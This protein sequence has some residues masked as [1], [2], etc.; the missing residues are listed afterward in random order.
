MGIQ[1][2]TEPKLPIQ[3]AF[4]ILLA[5]CG[6]ITNRPELYPDNWAPQSSDREWIPPGAVVGHYTAESLA[7]RPTSPAITTF[8]HSQT[9]DLAGLIDIALRNNPETWRQW[10]AARSAAAQFGAAEAPYYPQADAQS[11]NGYER[12]T[13]ELPG[14]PGK[15]N[16][17]ESQP[18][19]EIT[20][21]LL[22][23]GRRRSAAEAARNRLIAN[24]F[25]FNRTIQ[26]VVFKTQG[27]FYA[28]D[29]AQAAVIAAEQNLQLAQTDFEAVQQRVNLG[30]AT[31]PE[32]LLAKE[33]AAQS[34]F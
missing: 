13:V 26:D 4:F 11:I 20:Y 19:M 17:W 16:Q 34:R 9:Y 29:A 5:G 30:L 1:R 12:T 18:V 24:N 31:Q 15:L 33:R 3:I 28:L 7:D 14:L 32:L 21:T 10:E 23:F 22:D 2:G 27:S 8:P 25:I 6:S